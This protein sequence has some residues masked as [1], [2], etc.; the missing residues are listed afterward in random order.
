MSI[1]IILDIAVI[2]GWNEFSLVVNQVVSDFLISLVIRFPEKLKNASESVLTNAVRVKLIALSTVLSI[3][4]TERL[5]RLLK[6]DSPIATVLND[7]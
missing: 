7:P 5:E 3:I 6:A 2:G 1:I 4:K